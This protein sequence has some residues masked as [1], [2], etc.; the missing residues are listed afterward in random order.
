MLVLFLSKVLAFLS[1]QILLMPV[2]ATR[3]SGARPRL[4]HWLMFC[5]TLSIRLS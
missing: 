1:S 2:I 3:F 5:I 4:S